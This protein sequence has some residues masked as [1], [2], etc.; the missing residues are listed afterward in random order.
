MTFENPS[1]NPTNQPTSPVDSTAETLLTE[2]EAADYMKISA[3]TVGRLR[4]AGKLPF[5]RIGFR[6]VYSIE[7]HIR[8]FLQGCQCN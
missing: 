7:N 6:V 3:M 5:Y 1:P 4:K 8:P 2:K